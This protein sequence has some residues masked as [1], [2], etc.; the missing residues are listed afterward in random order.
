M[1]SLY[2][3]IYVWIHK[4]VYAEG[5][6]II[7]TSSRTHYHETMYTAVPAL[8]QY[9]RAA[10]YLTAIQIYL[11]D[12]YLLEKPLASGHIKP[13]LLGHWGT[14]PGINFV[15]A[16]MNYQITRHQLHM[17]FVLGPGHGFPALQANLLLEGTL[18]DFY[19]EATRTASGIGYITKKFSWPYGFPSHSNPET[20]GVI[21]EGGELGYALATAY[22]A[23]LDQP[24]LIVPCL[25]GDGEAETGPT[26]TAWH[27]NKFVDP[28]TCGA[29]LP[30]LHL[31]GYKISGPTIF[32]R[33]SHEELQFLF[34]GYGY[35]PLFIDIEEGRDI[36]ESALEV[37]ELAITK[38]KRIQEKARSGNGI[39]AFRMPMIILKTPKGWTTAQE[40]KGDKIEGNCL[41]HQVVF[42]HAKENPE[43]LQ[44]LERWLRGYRFDELFDTKQGFNPDITSLV[45]QKDLCMGSNKIAQGDAFQPLELPPLDSYEVQFDKPGSVTASSMKQSGA[46]MR[47]I[48]TA[49][50]QRR[51]FR[52]FSPDETYSNKINAIFESTKRAFTL[53][54]EPWDKD[55]ARD[56]MVIEVLS[57]HSLQGMLQGYLLTGRHGVFVSYEAFIQIVS[58]MV[59]QYIKFLK[60]ARE[61]PWRG[62]IPS[63]NFILTSSGWRQD[64]NGFS[65][66]NPSF[67]GDAIDV[68]TDFIKAY[69][70]ADAN[71]T[72]AT[73]HT[74]LRSK[75]GINIITAGKTYEPQWITMK[76]AVKQ[77]EDGLGIWEF[78][79][80]INP[81]L[82]VCGIGDYMTKEALAAVSLIKQE[83]PQ[84]SIRF[85]NVNELTSLTSCDF[86]K[87]FTEHKPVIFNYH[88]YC[89]VM[90][91]TLYRLG[92]ASRF[93]IRGY[94][95]SG[96]TTTPYDMHV[97][98]K[99]SRWHLALYAFGKLLEAGKLTKKRTKELEKKYTEKFEE[100]LRYIQEYGVD[101]EEITLM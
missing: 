38:I 100:H 99:T 24:D 93:E 61:V 75:N 33:M 25:I 60:V 12:N 26:A 80:D 45:P 16:F 69:Y 53:P 66:Q 82:V 79:S 83:V 28:A 56:G 1:Y 7:Y 94:T 11:Q 77:L 95:E 2:Y 51:N 74:C 63:M 85:V 73:L 52:I 84:A 49:N 35:E 96:S 4:Q 20:P 3:L 50:K 71:A 57:E 43:E 40:W 8:K 62:D 78:A 6:W 98:N 97:R 64:H 89:E 31:N 47:D 22:G 5:F 23:V 72:V 34:T 54:H 101:L 32:G 36:Y 88:G 92:D 86:R 65:H 55:I 91:K 9:V 41:S 67:V 27:L 17:L 14:C 46:F 10:N 15:Y 37:F 70:P 42:P 81:D 58:S 21:V 39:T 30:I 59:D 87:Y 76:K 29:V 44:Q 19:P 48:I 13:R 68:D 90:E 18:E